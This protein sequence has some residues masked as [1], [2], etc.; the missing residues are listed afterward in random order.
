MEQPVLRDAAEP[1]EDRVCVPMDWPTFELFLKSR[2]ER[3]GTRVTYLDGAVEIM[4][5]SFNHE[6]LKENL[7]FLLKLWAMEFRLPLYSMGSTTLKKARRKAGAEPDTSFSLRPPTV[8]ATPDIAIEVV[9]KSPLLDK[10]EVYRRL[11]VNEV[12]VWERGALTAWK[13][14]GGVWK[15][16][17]KSSLIPQL[18]L[19]LLARYAPLNLGPDELDA[20]RA[21]FRRH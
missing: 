5:P 17:R 3:S 11:G 19:T 2:G 20:F 14:A 10:L 7:G 21:E 6:R 18:D 4:A 12:W 8:N 9:W 1:G 13:C 16:L 15:K